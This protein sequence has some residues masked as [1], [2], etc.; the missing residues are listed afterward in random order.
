VLELRWIHPS[1]RPL[2]GV[3]ITGHISICT[4]YRLLI[5]ELLPS[6]VD[7]VIYLDV[8]AVVLGDIGELWDHN[9][10]SLAIGAVPE[11][12]LTVAS[13]DGLTMYKELGLEPHMKMFNAGVLLCNL[14]LWRHMNTGMRAMTFVRQYAGRLH[15]WDQ[16]V[17]NALFARS[18]SRLDT[19]WNYRVH[20]RWE[21]DIGALVRADR[22][23]AII[24]FNSAVKPWSYG[25]RHPAS[26]WYFALVDETSW[27]GW[28]PQKPR[29]TLPVAMRNMSDKHW[30]GKWMRKLPLV[31]R[32]WV[33]L[34][35][36]RTR[37][38]R[39]RT[40]K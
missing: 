17:L 25:V 38:A 18:W 8:D 26:S 3:P 32:L 34:V 23:A 22:Q 15:F 28:R 20:E 11:A 31:G 24:H 2:R 37:S 39:L 27:K 36:W 10:G 7:T 19:R 16:D 33:V 12:G 9:L 14:G 13:P 5:A 21:G 6:D 4:Y 29:I 35:E 30:Y 40:E 1:H